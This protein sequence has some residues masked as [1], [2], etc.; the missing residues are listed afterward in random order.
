MTNPRDTT[1]IDAIAEDWVNTE[2]D[3]YPE[4][5]VYLGRPGHEGEYADYSPAGAENAVEQTRSAL[6]RVRAARWTSSATSRSPSTSTR[7]ASG[8]ATST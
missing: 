2:L 1:P 7:P 8:S 4:L 3:L 5:R 6:A